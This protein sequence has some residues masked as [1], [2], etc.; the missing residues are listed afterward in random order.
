MNYF[1]TAELIVGTSFAIKTFEHGWFMIPLSY[2]CA[3]P[4]AALAFVLAKFVGEKSI[5]DNNRSIPQQIRL[6]LI[7]GTVFITLTI[8]LVLLVKD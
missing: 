8:V 5:A 3:V 7:G 4:I 1:L 2:L 6:G